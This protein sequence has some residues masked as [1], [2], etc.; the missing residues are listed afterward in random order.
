MPQDWQSLFGDRP[1]AA[2]FRRKFHRPTNLE[3]HERVVLVFAEIRGTGSV[4]L[5][6]EPVGNFASAGLPVEFEI[7]AKLNAFNVL[8][9]EIAFDPEAESIHPGGISGP[10]ALE[11]RW[12]TS[13]EIAGVT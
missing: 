3:P 8:T 7:T 9:V 1:G 2:Q 5:N 10:V 6:D 13:P 12:D 11:I 4:R